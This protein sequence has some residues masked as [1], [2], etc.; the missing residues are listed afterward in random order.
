MFPEFLFFVYFI[1]NQFLFFVKICLIKLKPKTAGLKL[2]F[3]FDLNK[4]LKFLHF[5]YGFF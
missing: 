3:N 4:I 5:V 2:K 1:F